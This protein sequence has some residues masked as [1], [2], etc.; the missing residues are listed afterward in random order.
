MLRTI[1]Y[2]TI[3]QLYDIENRHSNSFILTTID[4]I[5]YY[6]TIMYQALGIINNRKPLVAGIYNCIGPLANQP[7]PIVYKCF[8]G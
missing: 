2:V 1:H 4:V 7:S 8:I 3:T 5:G 6:Q